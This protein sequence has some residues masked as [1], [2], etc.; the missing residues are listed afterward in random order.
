MVELSKKKFFITGGSR[1]IG[2]AIVLALAEAGAQVAFT[3]STNEEK[4]QALVKSLPGS[5][6]L[7]LQMDVS[8]SNSVDAA[9]NQVITAWGDVDGVVNNAGITRDQLLLRMKVEDFEKVIST[10][11]T[12]VFSVTKAFSKSMLKARKGSFVNISS[13]IGS[14]GNAGQSNYAA[15]KGGLEAFTKSVALEFASRGIRANCIA[16]GY[17]KSDMTDSLTE[18]QLKSFSDK[19]PLSR[20][21]EGREIATAVA[22]LLSDAASYITG[23]TLH[24]NGGM[25]L[26]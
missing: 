25:Y 9:V 22:F 10:N 6:H 19:I 1:G 26:N 16:P 17:I 2:S 24:V 20:P 12:G 4:A 13:V 5:N 23:Q 18:E 8:D 7:C 15:S 14:V 21:G 3:F 11:L